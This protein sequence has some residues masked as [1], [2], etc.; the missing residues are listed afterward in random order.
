[1]IALSDLAG[2]AGIDALFGVKLSQHARLITLATAQDSALPQALVAERFSGRE[3]VNEL[4]DFEIDALSTSTDLDLAEFIGEEITLGLLQ[5]DGSRRSWHGLCV[6]AEWLGADGGLARYRL[7]LQPALALL[8]LR[9]DSYIFQDKNARDLITE[10]LADYPQVRFEFDVSQELAVRPIWTQYRENDLEFLQRVLAAE[11]LSWR[12]EH[13][14]GDA[15]PSDGQQHARHKVVFF[16]S[17]AAL[18]ATPGGDVLRFHGVRATDVD[19]AIDG[20]AARRR[21]Q[22]NAVT[23]SSWDPAQLVAPAAEQSSNLEIGELPA[24]AIYDGS[25]ERRHLDNADADLHSR[26]MLQ[27]L[28]LDNKQFEGAGAVRRM[29][30]GHGFQLTQHENHG[31]GAN[32]FTAL[33]IEHEAR[34]NFGPA[35]DGAIKQL[36][37]AGKE[38]AA[39]L[40]RFV[41]DELEPGTYRNRFA[42]VRDTVAIV[43][44][45][46][47]ARFSGAALGPQTALIVGLPETINTTTREHQVRIQFAWQRGAASNPGGLAHDTDEKSNAPGNDASG[48]WVRVAEALAGP[49]WGSQFTPRIGTEVLVDFIEGDMDR[50]LVV[51]QLY[52]GSDTP[53]FSAGVDTEVNHAGVISGIHSN[54]FDG[55]GYN[56]WVVDDTSGQVRTRLATSSAA[57]QLNLGYL[58]QQAIGSAQR[59]SYRGQG[60]ELRTD[61]WAVVRGGE[62]TLISATARAQQGSGVTSTQLD[63]AEAVGLLRGAAQ[64]NTVLIDA[65][66]QQKALSSKDAQQAQKDFIEQ[67]DPEQ[68]GKFDAGVGGQDALKASDGARELDAAAPV[69]KFGQP[70]VLVE[71]PASINWATPA[72]TTVF[73][74]GQLQWTTQADLHMAA[75]HTVASVSANATGLF[76]HDGG[77][78]AMAANGLVSLQAHTDQLEILADKAI[79]FLS[80]NDVI[81]I[82]AQE[83][84]VLQAGQSSVTLEGGNITF[85]CP[86]NFSVKGS[87]HKFDSGHRH[88]TQLSKLPDVSAG[89]IP[90]GASKWLYDEQIEF[91]N[92]NNA[93]L[94]NVAYQLK[95]EDGTVINGVTDSKGKT[96]RITNIKPLA[97]VEAQ[98]QHAGHTNCCSSN[99]SENDQ[100]SII[101][102]TGSLALNQRDIGRSTAPL[103]TE[104]GESRGLTEGEIAEARKIFFDSIDYA[105]VKIHNGEY[106]WFGLQPDDTAMTPNGEVYFNPKHFVDDFSK[107]EQETLI[108]FIHEMVHVWQYQL[109]YPVKWRGAI[110][111]GL[112]Y[113]Y[114][115]DE[116]K[117]LADFNMEAQGN[118]LAD[119]WALK[120]YPPR[121]R[122]FNERKHINDLSL[123]EKVLEKF[124]KNPSDPSNLPGG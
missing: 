56:Q 124:I 38:A 111:L 39:A 7:H 63:S 47:A 28:E 78:Q 85:A 14:Q 82:K 112:D 72:S 53:P 91:R 44:R 86:G 102:N 123:Y 41:G 107:G 76:T 51:A 94:A 74:G 89:I 71:G 25:A 122:A 1:M 36:L 54:N 75:A 12:F 92:V 61:A 84:I 80:V 9:R 18:P 66:G 20:F 115:L 32:A 31:D 35:L 4:F 83:K 16:D 79:T 114:T 60:F 90:V 109:G 93:L 26:L 88:E 95:L 30:A 6:D 87:Q 55:G 59:G 69:E 58:V 73:A 22:A 45:A 13:D 40:A 29:A 23:I 2:L 10:L 81:E 97:I 65:A 108:W 34:N 33:W 24:L 77:I 8:G 19:D 103:K 118:V 21:V 62:G 57:T 104:E 43:P 70:V 99:S 46:S 120:R 117:T 113:R 48:T 17:M 11:G 37:A 101:V 100:A 106:L 116:L 110:R 98:L 105:K 15:S 5:P 68:S 49:N 64:L 52:T 50:P 121:P 27:A 119:F 67:V 42:C 3:G 96:G